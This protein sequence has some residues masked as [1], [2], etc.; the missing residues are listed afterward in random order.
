MVSVAGAALIGSVLAGCSGAG[1]TSPGAEADALTTSVTVQGPWRSWSRTLSAR[2]VSGACGATTHQVVCS[3]A[4]DGLIGRSRVDGT[5]TWTV[6]ATGSNGKNA[7]LVVDAAD[8]RAVTGAG[9]TLRVANLRTGRAAWSHRAPAG[10]TYVGFA[11]ADGVVYALDAP[12]GSENGTLRAFRASDGT[13]VWQTSVE[14][15]SGEGLTAFGGRI[16]TTDGTKVTAHDARTGKTLA[17]GPAGTKCPHLIA[18]GGYLVCTGSPLSAEDSF[19]PLRRL[20]PATLKP[21]ATAEDTGMKPER[22]LISSDG[23]LMLFEDSAEDPGAGTWSAYDLNHPRRLWSYATT[24]KEAGLTGGRFVTFTPSNDT[25]KGRVITIDL[26]AGPD[27]TGTAAPRLSPAYPEA[28]ESVYPALIVPGADSGHVVV[29]ATAHHSPT[30][31]NALRS[32]PLP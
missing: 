1:T 8:E 29:E 9:R 20:D 23:V 27:G 18:G 17:A 5:V 32:V 2:E 22:G 30:A 10:R 4:P 16:Y 19:P 14:A 28:R 15:E 3:I 25:T 7:G 11:A 13:S 31:H 12:S 21:L 6:P 26:H 24:T